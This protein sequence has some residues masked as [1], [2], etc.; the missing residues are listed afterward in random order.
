MLIY[1]RADIVRWMKRGGLAY[2]RVETK[3]GY[4]VRDPARA[5]R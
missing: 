2:E 1:Y 3:E 4:E 5:N